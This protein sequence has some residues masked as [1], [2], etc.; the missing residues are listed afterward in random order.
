M[1]SGYASISKWSVGKHSFVTSYQAPSVL[2]LYL[3]KSPVTLYRWLVRHRG[4]GGDLW[5]FVIWFLIFCFVRS[6]AI[7]A[8]ICLPL[9]FFL[10]VRKNPYTFTL[11]MAQALVTALMISSRSDLTSL[12]TQ[13]IVNQITTVNLASCHLIFQLRHAACHVP[14]RWGEQSHW[15]ADYSICSPGGCHYQHGRNGAL[16]GGCCHLHRPNEWLFSGR[17]PNCY[18][19]VKTSTTTITNKSSM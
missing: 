11:G 5:L 9:L 3:F 6:L 19:Q 7:H 16:W 17:G 12:C 8:T 18:Y 15:Q 2:N 1:K 4:D 13:T 10:V 14:M